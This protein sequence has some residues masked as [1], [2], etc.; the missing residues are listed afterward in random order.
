MK[1][2]LEFT[3]PEESAEHRLAC[4]GAKFFSELRDLGEALRRWQKYGH[5]FKSA[6]QVI[7]ALRK[8][9]TDLSD[10]E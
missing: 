8:Q 7:D 6:D 10:Y 5:P 4:D 9:I 3:L 2:T 1:A